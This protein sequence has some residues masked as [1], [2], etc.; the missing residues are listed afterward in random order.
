M[1]ECSE[2]LRGTRER[3][4]EKEEKKK[5]KTLGR[6]IRKRRKRREVENRRSEEGKKKVGAFI[7]INIQISRFVRIFY[8]SCHRLSFRL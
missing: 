2:M 8:C 5:E 1:G 4:K 6:E 3:K 7:R